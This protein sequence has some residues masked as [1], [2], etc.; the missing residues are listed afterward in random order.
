MGFSGVMVCMRKVLPYAHI[1]GARAG[2]RH[3]NSPDFS[4]LVAIPPVMENSAVLT[5]WERC[6]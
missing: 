1:I 6:H 3:L 2:D 5:A 4:G